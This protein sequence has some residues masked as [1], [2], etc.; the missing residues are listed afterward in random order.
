MVSTGVMKYDK[1]SA[2]DNRVKMSNL[3]N[4]RQQQSCSCSV[5]CDAAL[6]PPVPRERTTAPAVRQISSEHEPRV[7]FVTVMH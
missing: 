5:S 3:K 7:A 4:K 2:P 1:R 6:T